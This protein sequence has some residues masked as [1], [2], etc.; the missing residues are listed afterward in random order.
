VC[1]NV[2][3]TECLINMQI[4]VHNNELLCHVVCSQRSATVISIFPKPQEE[5]SLLF[6][7]HSEAEQYV[8]LF[9]CQY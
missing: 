7:R 8:C 9:V 3:S 1:V 5:S 4:Y 2:Y 6:A